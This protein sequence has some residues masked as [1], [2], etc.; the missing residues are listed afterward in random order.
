MR[1]EWTRAGL[2]GGRRVL[3]ARVGPFSVK[4]AEIPGHSI[5][6]AEWSDVLLARRSYTSMWG[7]DIAEFEDDPADGRH[8]ALYD[9]RHYLAWVRYGGDPAKLVTMRK[10]R[11]APWALTTNQQPSDADHLPGDIGFWR[12]RTYGRSL[13][14]W[15]VLKAHARRQSP[16]DEHAEYRIATIGRISTFPHGR[17]EQSGRMLE[18]TAIA[19]AVI[20]LLAADGD[21]GP[22]WVCMLCPE[23]QE[24]VLGVLDVNGAYVA[25]AFTRTEEVLDLPRGSV[26]LDASSPVV[27]RHKT[28]YPG[29][30]V[31]NDDAARFLA[32]LLASGGIAVGD[33][34]PA[35]VRL[36]IREWRDNK[37]SPA[38]QELLRLIGTSDHRRLVEILTAPRLFKYLSTLVSGDVRLSRMPAA[39]FR[40]R[41]LAETADGP[42]SA[43]L[44]LAEWTTSARA[45]LQAAEEKY[46]DDRPDRADRPD[47]GSGM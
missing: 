2:P 25:P 5:S 11:I 41:F 10:A 7:G 35:I 26:L 9:T 1:L 19:F 31:D 33:L 22:L 36:V 6:D 44:R 8:P 15:D 4:V 13:P 24:R 40:R 12:V 18:R 20:Q 34:R 23:L 17:A 43:T 39:E 37:D 3:R 21:S 27:Q 46:A 32:R 16:D 45:V 47:A 14:L 38:L 28:L 29:Y 30:F 42:F